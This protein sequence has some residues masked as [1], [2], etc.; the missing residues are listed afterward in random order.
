MTLYHIISILLVFNLIGSIVLIIINAN[1]E[2]R[3]PSAVWDF[4][5]CVCVFICIG[6]EGKAIPK[7]PETEYV[8]C[9]RYFQNNK[10]EEPTNEDGSRLCAKYL[11]EQKD[12]K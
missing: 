10:I 8:E 6:L 7:N 12:A 9:I 5:L 2:G 3:A 11:K 1:S 4:I